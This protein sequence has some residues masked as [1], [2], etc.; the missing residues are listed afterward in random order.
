MWVIIAY[1]KRRI[2]AFL[3]QQEAIP[4]APAKGGAPTFTQSSWALR[5]FEMRRSLHPL[6]KSV[7]GG[8]RKRLGTRSPNGP[9]LQM[10]KRSPY[11]SVKNYMAYP[12]P[13]P[14]NPKC[15]EDAQGTLNGRWS[16]P[17]AVRTTQIQ[18]CCEPGGLA[19]SERESVSGL[20]APPPLLKDFGNPLSPDC[21]N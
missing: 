10:R 1:F 18:Y 19:N 16:L 14:N 12:G 9:I 21:W 17:G 20:Y 5:H 4:A 6:G 11:S 15:G 7:G 2:G 8:H 13:E 3:I